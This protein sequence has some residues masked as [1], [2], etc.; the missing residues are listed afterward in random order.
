[1]EFLQTFVSAIVNIQFSDILDIV[2]VAFLIYKLLPLFKS[3]GTARI[4][5]LVVFVIVIAWVTELARLHTIS[6]ILNQVLAIGLLAVVVLFQPEL[7]RMIDHL[8]S[9][10][11][12]SFS[13]PISRSRRWFLSSCRPSGP[14][15]Q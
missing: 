5:A 3:T 9:T 11:S 1:M 4:A 15:R 14:V 6:W 10:K 13:A 2:I 8:S 12:K 7:R